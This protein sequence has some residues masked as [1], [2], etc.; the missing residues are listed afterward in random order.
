MFEVVSV[1][2]EDV[3]CFVL[4][5]PPGP[6]TGCDLGGGFAG[7][8]QILDEA[9]AA[10]HAPEASERVRVASEIAGLDRKLASVAME[11]PRSFYSPGIEAGMQTRVEVDMPLATGEGQ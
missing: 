10:G 3:E 1:V 2:L 5:F 4:D 7:H 9:V 6:T 8:R 11:I